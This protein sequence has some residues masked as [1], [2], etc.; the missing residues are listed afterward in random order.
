M[1]RVHILEIYLPT[2][3]YLLFRKR[4]YGI[5]S[6]T[7]LGESAFVGVFMLQCF[8]KSQKYSKMGPAAPYSAAFRRENFHPL[9]SKTL[10]LNQPENGKVKIRGFQLTIFRKLKTFRKWIS[11]RKV[12]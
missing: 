1:D 12:I 8:K 5:F 3:K 7:N 9:L 10:Q 6:A 4:N 11:F 2:N